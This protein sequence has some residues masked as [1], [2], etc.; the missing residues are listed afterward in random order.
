MGKFGRVDI[1][2]MKQFQKE[3]K[4]LQ[5]RDAF[6]EACAKELAARLLSMVVKRTPVGDYSKEVKVVAKRNSKYHKK[7]DVYTK[8]VKSKEKTGGTLR[9]GWIS[10]TQ[11]EAQK[12]KTAISQEEILEYANGLKVSRF[13]KTYKIEIVNPVEYALT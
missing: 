10:E 7:G 6:M 2:G 5:D 11:E 13:G 9:R 4:K 8:R 12:G 3:L 1:R